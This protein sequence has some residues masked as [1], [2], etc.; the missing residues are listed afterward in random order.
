MVKI[1]EGKYYRTLEGEKVGPMKHE[2]DGM[3]FDA[4]SIYIWRRD[5]ARFFGD[6]EHA[7]ISEWT[8]PEFTLD[9]PHGHVTRNGRKARIICTDAKDADYPV[10]A[11]VEDETTGEYA[12]HFTAK[13]EYYSSGEKNSLDLLN[14]PAPKREWWVNV[15][16][17]GKTSTWG[18][19][20]TADKYATKS[21]IACV[22]VTEGDGL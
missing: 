22:H 20:E 9:W 21:R 17:D 5:G 4:A 18:A 19:R 8:E 1:E 11:L 15:Y 10:V 13:G 7:I 16:A 3:W 12:E 6:A 2:V 14:A